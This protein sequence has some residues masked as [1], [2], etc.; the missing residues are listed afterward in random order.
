MATRWRFAASTLPACAGGVSARSASPPSSRCTLLYREGRTL[1]QAR[2]AI[3]SLAAEMP[4]AAQDVAM[5][6]GFPPPPSAAS[7]V[8]MPDP[9]LAMVAGEASGDLLAG[10]LL[11]GLHRRWPQLR[12]VGIGGPQM[13]AAASVLVAARKLAVSGYVE[14]LRHRELVGIRNELRE[15]LLVER[16]QVFVGG[17]TRLQPRPEAALKAQGIKT[18]HFVCPSI[19]ARWP[20]ARKRFAAVDHAVCLSRAELLARHGIASTY[21]G[22]PLAP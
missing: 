16:P 20:N 7:P 1:E 6:S 17:R 9:T 11:D 12:A 22:H 4:E 19:W 21:V 15:R 14:V 2:A 10:L 18:V 5:M 3:E 8:A 13:D